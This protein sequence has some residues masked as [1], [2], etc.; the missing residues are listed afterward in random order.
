VSSEHSNVSYKELINSVKALIQAAK[1]FL[2]DSMVL[3]AS[4]VADAQDTLEAAIE[5]VEKVL[6]EV[7][8]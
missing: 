7:A 6:D 5:D 8:E 1:P 3:L 2:N 4:A